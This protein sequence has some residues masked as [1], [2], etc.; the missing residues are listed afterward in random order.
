MLLTV[1]IF[2]IQ[3]IK[4]FDAVNLLSYALINMEVQYFV[5]EL[6]YKNSVQ[7]YTAL[8]HVRI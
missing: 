2:V 1:I 5:L 6:N 4:R 8:C 7:E 3:C